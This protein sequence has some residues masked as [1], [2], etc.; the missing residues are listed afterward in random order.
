MSLD[1]DLDQ[2]VRIR[3]ASVQTTTRTSSRMIKAFV[4]SKSFSEIPAKIIMSVHHTKAKQ[5][6]YAKITSA[7]AVNNT[8]STM[9][10]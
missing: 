1:L 7:F 5:Q 10:T 4:S 3:S 6:W 8:S 2:F 9:P